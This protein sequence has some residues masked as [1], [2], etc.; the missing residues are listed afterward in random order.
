MSGNPTANTAVAST[1]LATHAAALSVASSLV[2]PIPLRCVARL[3]AGLSDLYADGKCLTRN[4]LDVEQDSY[5]IITPSSHP[6][7]KGLFSYGFASCTATIIV[8][9]DRQWQYLSHDTLLPE[10]LAAPTLID[11]RRLTRASRTPCE[12]HIGVSVAAYRQAV[13]TGEKDVMDDKGNVLNL[14]NGPK[15]EAE[16]ERA[17]AFVETWKSRVL[18][19]ARK[20]KAKTCFDMPNSALLVRRDPFAIHVFQTLDCMPYAKPARAL[21]FERDDLSRLAA[22]Q[23]ALSD[24]TPTQA[25]AATLASA[26]EGASAMPDE[27]GAGA[28]CKSPAAAGASPP[29]TD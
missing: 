11:V 20:V 4:V 14:R 19:Y 12:V 15:S 18:N 6:A 28:G 8:S 13:L 3:P 24:G 29:A 25:A 9:R 2:R 16:T 23:R 1:A 5:E 27:D 21:D 17:L 22:P 7:V 10:A 26:G